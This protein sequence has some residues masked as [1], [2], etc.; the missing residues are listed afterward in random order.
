MFT[1]TA[2]FFLFNLSIDTLFLSTLLSLILL[3]WVHFFNSFNIFKSEFSVFL[4]KYVTY[5]NLLFVAILQIFFWFFF[6]ESNVNILNLL[7]L[8]NTLNFQVTADYFNYLMTF[9]IKHNF[10]F[11]SWSINIDLFALIIQ[12]AGLVVGFLSYLVLDTRYFFKNIK[13]LTVFCI[14]DI[15]VLL[16]TTTNNIIF[17][18]LFYELL[19]LPS[20]LLVYY[21]SQA[22]RGI[23]ASLY[24]VIWTQIGSF[25]VLCAT[26]YLLTITNI[27]LF[28][29]L[30]YFRFTQSEI[31]TLY[32][33]YFF[34][35][36]FKV[37]IWPLHFW[38]TKTHV[39]ASAGFSMYLS[40]FLVK[41]ALYGFFKYTSIF[42]LGVNTTFFI[43]IA[44]I[45]VV[46]ASIKMFSQVDLKK[47]VAFCTIQEMNLIYLMLCWGDSFG[48]TT[49]MLFILTHAFL[50][51][52]MFFLVD[53]IQRRYNSRSVLELSGILHTTPN[54]G[55][56]VFVM[57]ILYSGLPGTIKFICEF[58][59]F[60]QLFSISF[61]FTF[62][63]IIFANLIG[64]V[65]FCRCFFNVLFGMS[66]KYSK[67][68]IV[69]LT[70]KDFYIIF[71]CLFFLIFLPYIPLWYV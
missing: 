64:V 40:G 47:L 58:Y 45:G 67:M 29:D 14:F 56:S 69:D 70:I 31:Y 16:F 24:F 21:V 39:E 8:D 26:A 33:L 49:A 52:L 23:Q 20:F 68:N 48:I 41:T 17:F 3:L 4:L 12:F 1:K 43:V 62:F 53:C 57:C 71:I 15:V 54:L 63:L 36:G 11:T 9:N 34:G 2:I 55:I 22:R 46:D 51:S 25:L 28:T 27:F 5:F 35:F 59:L 37:P 60:G 18:F 42:G 30:K 50:S 65:G 44:A 6:L 7:L 19:L 32:T 38:L 61:W 10:F 13:Y 66:L